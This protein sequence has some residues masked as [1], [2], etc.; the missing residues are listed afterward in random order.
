MPHYKFRFNLS[1]L[2]LFLLIMLPNLYWFAVPAPQDVLRAPS[3]TETLDTV[4]S[5]FQVLM[6]AAL[7]LIRAVPSPRLRLSP[8]IGATLTAL[9]LYLAAWLCYYAGATAPLVLLTL[10]TAP[11]LSFLF[12]AID[13]R[14]FPALVPTVLFTVCHLTCG[15]ANYLI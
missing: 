1:A 2:V 3:A 7:C 9:V 11:C 15:I 8:L 6:V 14:N 12:Y 10:C 4:A 5:V 13:R